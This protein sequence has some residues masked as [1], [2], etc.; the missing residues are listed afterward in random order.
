[1][2]YH[3]CGSYLLLIIFN[4][5][6]KSLLLIDRARAIFRLTALCESI[7]FLGILLLSSS[8]FFLLLSSFL[9][10][11]LPTVYP[12]LVETFLIA[13]ILY[14]ISTQL[15]LNKKTFGHGWD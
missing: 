9:L 15:K 4:E 5:R 2:S 13:Y 12:R 1:M 3:R 7:A 10:F 6:V 14:L 11:A 8:F